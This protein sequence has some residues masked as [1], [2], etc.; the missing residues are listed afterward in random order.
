M[1]ETNTHVPS[2][3]TK[4]KEVRTSIHR[5]QRQRTYTAVDKS[6]ERRG[7]EESR[8]GWLRAGEDGVGL[9]TVLIGPPANVLRATWS[10]YCGARG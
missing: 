4:N 7:R 9:A 8:V 2:H 10:G 6:R 1:I 5:N 3:E